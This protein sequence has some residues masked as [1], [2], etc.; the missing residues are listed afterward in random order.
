[1]VITNEAKNR[2]IEL[3]EGDISSAIHGTDG[4]DPNV[5]DTDLGAPVAATSAAVTTTIGE[6]LLNVKH[7]LTANDGNGTTFREFGIHT[8]ADTKLMNHIVYPDFDK[9]GALEL[10]TITTIRVN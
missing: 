8:M 4:T 9:S 6:K 7:I 2:L 10:H 1:M 3:L 5:G